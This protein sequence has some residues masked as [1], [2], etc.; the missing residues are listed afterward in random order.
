MDCCD[1][2]SRHLSSVR[3]TGVF[4]LIISHSAYLNEEKSSLCCLCESHW[5]WTRERKEEICLRRWG[6]VVK[7]KA[8]KS[9]PSSLLLLWPQLPILSRSLRSIAKGCWPQI[10]QKFKWNH[11]KLPNFQT[12]LPPRSRYNSV[13]SQEEHFWK[14][15]HKKAWEEFSKM[16]VDKQQYLWENCMRAFVFVKYKKQR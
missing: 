5:T 7:V 16:F 6:S 1:I 12:S 2:S 3:I 13:Q 15:K 11:G 8:T 4:N 9:S 14:Q 10:E